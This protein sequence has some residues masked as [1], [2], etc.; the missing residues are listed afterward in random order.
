MAERWKAVRGYMGIYEVSDI[1]NVRRIAPW[2]DGRKTKPKP[3]FAPYKGRYNR[4]ILQFDGRKRQFPVHRL[5]YEAFREEIPS[6][7]EINHIN[8]IKHDN[9]LENLEAITHAENNRHALDVLKRPVPYGSKHWK[10]KLSEDEVR[11][12]ILMTGMGA[13]GSHLAKLFNVSATTI[14]EIFHGKMW[15]HVHI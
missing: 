5:V 8:G 2:C 10:S 15:K 12:I 11:Q 4:V 13:K 3:M 1:G 7:L 9:R 6:G 14:S